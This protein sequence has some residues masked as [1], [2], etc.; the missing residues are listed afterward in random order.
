MEKDNVVLSLTNGILYFLP[1]LGFWVFGLLGCG[2]SR[3]NQ[4]TDIME[5]LRGRGGVNVRM[6]VR[7]STNMD[8]DMIGN[9]N[10]NV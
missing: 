5:G 3:M 1:C 6:N 8:M 2:E 10:V 9:V 7:V 4:S